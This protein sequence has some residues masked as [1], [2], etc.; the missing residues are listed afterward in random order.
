MGAMTS[1]A[2]GNTARAAWASWLTTALIVLTIWAAT[3]IGSGE[4]IYP[5]PIWVIGPWGAVLVAQTLTGRRDDD[6][7]LEGRAR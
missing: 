6:R 4:W 2:G 7:R 1:W 3:S 5:W